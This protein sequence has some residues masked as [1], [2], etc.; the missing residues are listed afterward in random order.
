[1]KEW[2]AHPEIGSGVAADD[3]HGH[4]TATHPGHERRVDEQ[5]N[6]SLLGSLPE[7]RQPGWERVWSVRAAG[8]FVLALL[9]MVVWSLGPAWAQTAASKENIANFLRDRP[10]LAAHIRQVIRQ[11]LEMRGR[12]LPGNSDDETLFRTMEQDPQTR[13]AVVAELRT[14]GYLGEAGSAASSALLREPVPVTQAPAGDADPNRPAPVLR[15]NPYPGIPSLNDLYSQV[16][17]Q[18]AAVARFGINIFRNSAAKLADLAMDLPVGPDYVLG[19]GDGLNVD[20][21]GGVSQRWTRTVDREGRVALPEAGTIVVAGRTLG[22]AQSSIQHALAPQFRNVKVDVSLTRVRTVRVYVVGE[23]QNPGAYDLSSL[24][25]PLNAL[26]AAGG[27]TERGSLR[28]VRQYRGQR[29]VREVD[30][31]DL[32]IRGVRS[33][34]ER[35]LPGD[36]VLVRPVGLQVTVSGMVR[37]PATYEL[38]EET[39]LS[40]VLELAGGVLVSATL[41][42]VKIERIQAHEKRV[43]LSLDLPQTNDEEELRQILSSF[44]L[45]DGDRVSI[46]PILPYSQE[47]VYL[48]GHVSRPGKYPFR[49]GLQLSDLI[50]SGQELLPEPAEQGEIVRLEGP[51]RQPRTIRFQL[52]DVLAGTDP[53]LLQPWDTV[54]LY[55][56]YELDAPKVA[57]YGEVLRPGEYPLS[58]GMTAAR[59]VAMAGGFKRSAYRETADLSS[60]VVQN[61]QRVLTRQGVVEI[62]KAVSGE[63]TTAD[64]ALKPGDLLTIRQ[65]TGWSDIGATVSVSGEVLYPGTYGIQ[66]GERLSSVIRRAGK[67][68]GTA[69]PAGTVLER[70]E[71]KALG[72]KAKTELI[73]QIESAS[74]S[75]RFAPA[76]SGQGQA[77]TMQAMLQ[78]RDQVVTMLRQRPATGRL[79]IRISSQLERWQDTFADIELR[80]GDTVVIPKRA[81]FVLVNGQVYNPTAITWTP[82]KSA[83][84]YLGQAGGTTETANRKAIFII[85]ANGSVV[86]SAGGSRFFR[87]DVRNTRMQPGDMVVVPP[88]II[89]GSPAWKALLDTAQLTASLAIAARVA[90]S[91]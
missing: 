74:A 65:L 6:G 40:E 24:S 30:L 13:E 56:R 14:E 90:T 2:N 21:W 27:P 45:R 20:I 26:Y 23:V 85:R 51:E 76:A 22:E 15:P 7:I 79:V 50:G 39:R 3:L 18:P 62:G 46:D 5:L 12:P 91:F 55:G 8:P 9:A 49:S 81:D 43:M 44:V 57:I 48:E 34:P 80:A 37:R 66:E 87:S 84:W 4:E 86:S 25:T 33:D 1:M 36:T 28:Q 75:V 83:S 10:E 47:T 71:V 19:P 41:R 67:F 64:V 29:L 70:V 11:Q 68:R 32:L 31:Y 69:Y 78:Q 53:L 89:G 38:K 63:S 59:L 60:Y 35:L 17:A 72:E 58:R 52:A 77:A 88:K 61:G 42:Q 54:R 73:Q 82:G 16:P